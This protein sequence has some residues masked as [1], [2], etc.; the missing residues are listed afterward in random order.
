MYG[1]ILSKHLIFEDDSVEVRLDQQSQLLVSRSRA[2][3][4]IEI[5]AKEIRQSWTRSQ[6]DA[7]YRSIDTPVNGRVRRYISVCLVSEYLSGADGN[8][9]ATPACV[10]KQTRRADYETIHVETNMGEGDVGLVRGKRVVGVGGDRSVQYG[11]T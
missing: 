9:T 7:H 8:A 3:K 6:Y 11:R 1:R 4:H 2:I 5:K 10:Y